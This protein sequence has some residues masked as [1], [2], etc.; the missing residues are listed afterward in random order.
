MLAPGTRWDKRCELLRAYGIRY[1]VR[2][3]PAP[4][5]AGHIEGHWASTTHKLHVIKLRVE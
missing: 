1:Y 2:N 3:R 5:A 4:R